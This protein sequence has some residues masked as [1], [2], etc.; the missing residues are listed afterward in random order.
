M[1][2]K[3][4]ISSQQMP[5]WLCENHSHPEAVQMQEF[6]LKCSHTVDPEAMAKSIERHL[7]EKVPEGEQGPMAAEVLIHL[8]RHM[9]QPQVRISHL[10]RNMVDL[11][12]NI[13][14]VVSTRAEDDSPLVDVRAASLYI[15]EQWCPFRFTN[16]FVMPIR[17]ISI[18]LRGWCHT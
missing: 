13:R 17:T 12:E 6:I 8:Q 9:L 3:G 14:E 5:C 10:L 2:I 7:A 4:S 15:K 11:S 1:D 18:W 16:F